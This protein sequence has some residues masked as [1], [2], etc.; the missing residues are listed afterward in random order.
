MNSFFCSLFGG[1]K[2]KDSDVKKV[3]V[4]VSLVAARTYFS[5][6]GDHRFK[7]LD[8]WNRP[9]FLSL[10]LDVSSE[11]Y[12]KD[13]TVLQ[14]AAKMT[15]WH[16][17]NWAYW[18]FERAR[19]QAFQNHDKDKVLFRVWPYEKLLDPESAEFYETVSLAA[20][21]G[22]PIEIFCRWEKP[23]NRPEP[24]STLLQRRRHG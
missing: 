5:T 15:I 7:Y 8:S 1:K 12:W 2:K 23:I 10:S 24:G 19:S 21:S 4:Q 11:Q 17:E 14:G 22:Q 3:T 20:A 6:A 9:T 16:A 13:L 18:D